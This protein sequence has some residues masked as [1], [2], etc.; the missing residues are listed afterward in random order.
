MVR[1]EHFEAGLLGSDTHLVAMQGIAQLV[2]PAPEPQDPV[3][4]GRAHSSSLVYSGRLNGSGN[5]LWLALP[6]VCGW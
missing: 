4:V 1:K 2:A 3:A 6:L 5:C